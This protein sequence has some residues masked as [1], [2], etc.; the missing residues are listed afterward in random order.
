MEPRGLNPEHPTQKI[1]DSKRLFGK[2]LAIRNIK[3]GELFPVGGK[4]IFS[5]TRDVH[6]VVDTEGVADDLSQ[7]DEQLKQIDIQAIERLIE[8]QGADVHPELFR[9]CLAFS[10]FIRPHI[11]QTE[12]SRAAAYAD[13]TPKISELLHTDN[14]ACTEASIL[15]HLFFQK[16]NGQDTDCSIDSMVINGEFFLT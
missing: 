9:Q 4:S 6:M 12:E 7:L 1:V 13:K 8:A 14:I 15:A 5:D 16:Q 2:G 3:S 10:R 11:A